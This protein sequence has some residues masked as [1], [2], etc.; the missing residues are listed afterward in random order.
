MAKV[1]S[2]S[3]VEHMRELMQQQ[4]H[5]AART[6]DPYKPTLPMEVP[7]WLAA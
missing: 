2:D 1:L 5:G 3:M 6:K 4:L 7:Q